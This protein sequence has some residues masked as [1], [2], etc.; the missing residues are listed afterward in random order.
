MMDL[1]KPVKEVRNLPVNQ[2]G[3][4]EGVA[5]LGPKRCQTCVSKLGTKAAVGAA[6]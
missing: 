2:G 1:K 4:G 6:R 5:R 3:S